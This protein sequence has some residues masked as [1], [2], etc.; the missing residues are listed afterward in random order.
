MIAV[1]SALMHT[2]FV[3][4]ATDSTPAFRGSVIVDITDRQRAED[5]LRRSEAYLNEVF[6]TLP[7]G[8]AIVGRD[9]RYERVNPVY[10][11]RT[12]LSCEQIV[13]MHVADINGVGAFNETIKPKLD[14]CFA[15]E[16]V[17]YGRWST[18]F[19]PGERYHAITY[20]PLFVSGPV[21]SC[22]TARSCRCATALCC[23][24]HTFRGGWDGRN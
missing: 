11:D 6:L 2:S 4:P 17:S 14:R 18:R 24:S 10:E 15:G 20:S 13:G 7:D 23:R 9:Y 3:I 5:A 19:T 12:G 8:V 16:H 21:I 22:S 1:I